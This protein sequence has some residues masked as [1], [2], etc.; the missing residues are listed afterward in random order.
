MRG[1]GGAIP[2]SITASRY[3]D[4]DDGEEE[5]VPFVGDID[6]GDVG[7]ASRD[8]GVLL[9]KSRTQGEVLTRSACSD[10]KAIRK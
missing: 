4:D 1:A 7:S 3:S 8:R 2:T 5:D 9:Q 6:A 10:G